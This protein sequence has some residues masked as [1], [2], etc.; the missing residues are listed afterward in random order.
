MQVIKKTVVVLSGTTIKAGELIDLLDAHRRDSVLSVHF[1]P[2]HPTEIGS[3]DTV[4]LEIE[5]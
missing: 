1:S 2:G 3:R 4:R 5:G